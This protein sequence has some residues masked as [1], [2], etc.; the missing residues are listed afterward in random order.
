LRGWQPLINKGLVETRK[1]RYNRG[2]AVALGALHLYIYLTLLDSNN[3][4]TASGTFLPP[5]PHIRLMVDVLLTMN[6]AFCIAG[7]EVSCSFAKSAAN[8]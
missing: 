6:E 1:A 7:G 2:L 5:E 3:G 8:R 4:V